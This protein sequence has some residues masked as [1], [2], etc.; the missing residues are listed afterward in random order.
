M[1][2][3]DELLEVE[4]YWREVAKVVREKTEVADNWREVAVFK[5]QQLTLSKTGSQMGLST[6]SPSPSNDAYD[7][8]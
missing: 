2:Y 5:E 3:F 1:N 4:I 6:P 8:K 7:I